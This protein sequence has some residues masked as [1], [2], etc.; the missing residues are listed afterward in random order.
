M[1][2][3]TQFIRSLSIEQKVVFW[4]VIEPLLSLDKTILPAWSIA[5]RGGS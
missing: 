1:F 5:I 2:V 4:S 3:I